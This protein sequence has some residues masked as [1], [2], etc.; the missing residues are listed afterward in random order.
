MTLAT[1]HR[2]PH[3]I[4]L[5]FPTSV[6]YLHSFQLVAVQRSK[7]AQ[8]C[9]FGRW[10]ARRAQPVPRS[11]CT[12]APRCEHM[13]RW[14]PVVVIHSPLIFRRKSDFCLF[15]QAVSSSL[16]LG[17]SRLLLVTCGVPLNLN[18]HLNAYYT[19]I[20]WSSAS[21]YSFNGPSIYLHASP[22]EHMCGGGLRGHD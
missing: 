1:A 8:V 11:S 20:S 17:N 19:D 7:C 5:A 22:R 3:N 16:A 9:R 2:I 15:L 14:P 12:T 4:K 21:I 18:L 13:A 10:V 6:D